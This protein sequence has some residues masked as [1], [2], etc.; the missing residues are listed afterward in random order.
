MLSKVL[1]P[2]ISGTTKQEQSEVI[3][4]YRDTIPSAADAAF[5]LIQGQGSA[6]VFVELLSSHEIAPRSS[7]IS[8]VDINGSTFTCRDEPY[9]NAV[10]EV[11]SRASNIV[12]YSADLMVPGESSVMKG[13]LRSIATEYGQSRFAFVELGLN[14]YTPQNSIPALL[15]QKLNELQRTASFDSVDRECVISGGLFHVERLLPDPVLNEQF[16]LRNV[17]EEF[18]TKSLSSQG[19][20]K[21]CYGQPGVLSSLYFS[22][23]LHFEQPL[24]DDWVEVKT[25]AIGL[26][27]KV[28]SPYSLFVPDSL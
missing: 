20:I 13:F 7:I 14:S 2:A 26:N 4:L 27:M 8:F 5:N 18:V 1:E 11:I 17:E 16:S 6:P 19:P 24:Q 25:E 23:D 3:L 21:V 12:W 22:R 15:I 28:S 10:R 9:F